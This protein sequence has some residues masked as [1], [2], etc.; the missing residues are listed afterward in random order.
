M[1]DPG[2]TFLEEFGHLNTN[3]IRLL[4]EA[5]LFASLIEHGVP[6]NSPYAKI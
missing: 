3:T 4:T 5:G 2:K 1:Q 6:K